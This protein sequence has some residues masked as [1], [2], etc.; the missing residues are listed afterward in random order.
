MNK[1]ELG[2]IISKARKQNNLTQIELAKKLNVTDKAISNWETGKN[3][4]DQETIKNIEMILNIKLT[5]EN[6][7]SLNIKLLSSNHHLK[8]T[9][10]IL[11]LILTLSIFIITYLIHQ[12]NHNQIYELSLSSSQDLTLTNSHILTDN[13]TII[14]DLNELTLSIPHK[15]DYKVTLYYEEQKLVT[16]EN[17]HH[18]T[19]YSSSN[20]TPNINHFKLKI[21]YQDYSN[22]II[23]NTYNLTS[24]KISS[25]SITSISQDT[26]NLLK[27]NSYQEIEPNIYEKKVDNL[28]YKYY[29][30]TNTIYLEYLDSN[31]NYIIASSDSIVNIKYTI[32]K[33]NQVIEYK[34][35]NT[36]SSSPSYIEISTYL[37]KELNKLTIS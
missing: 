34:L 19:Y 6:D 15:P 24:T 13:S 33:N 16:K 35:D 7:N 2:Q 5:E 21:E 27:N 28:L 17:F 20:K 30:N 32:T 4:P 1:E 25:S 31:N 11:L 36:I 22:T 3:L 29:S 9:L 23:Q 26:L 14:I 8:I 10:I 37:I 12:I 18:L